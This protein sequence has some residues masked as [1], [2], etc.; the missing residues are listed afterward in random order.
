MVKTVHWIQY[1]N[2][3]TAE[4]NGKKEGKGFYKLMNNALPGKPMENLRNKVD[5]RIV[6]NQ[7]D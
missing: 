6:N 1:T 4:K 2:N 5:K 7:N 3:T